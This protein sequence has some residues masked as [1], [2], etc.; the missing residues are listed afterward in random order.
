[1]RAR[2][3]R[4]N[5]AF[6]GSSASLCDWSTSLERQPG[7]QGVNLLGQDLDTD[8]LPTGIG[9]RPSIACPA[10][11]AP[12]PRKKAE[13]HHLET[14]LL[15][16]YLDGTLPISGDLERLPSECGGCAMHPAK[17]RGDVARERRSIE[18]PAVYAVVDEYWTEQRH[19]ARGVQAHKRITRTSMY[20]VERARSP[21]DWNNAHM[22][23]WREWLIRYSNNARSRITPKL[24]CGRL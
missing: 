19:R 20:G 18:Y 6:V 24:T 9:T 4:Y 21:I 14:R 5:S 22:Q 12:D 3:A 10:G 7:S 23:G 1:M 15:V 8:D 11:D 13:G 2:S 17:L 16:E